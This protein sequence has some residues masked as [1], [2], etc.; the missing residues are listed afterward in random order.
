MPR[1]G[2][3]P[4]GVA[5]PTPDRLRSTVNRFGAP[6]SVKSGKRRDDW[7]M[8]DWGRFGKHFGAAV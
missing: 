1:V 7:E 8:C 5:R 6:R 4:S 2:P 3:T